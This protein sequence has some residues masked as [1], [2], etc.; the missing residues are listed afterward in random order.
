MARDGRL[1]PSQNA[2]RAAPERVPGAQ[3]AAMGVV[4]VQSR[5]RW[6]RRLMVGVAM[7]AMAASAPASAQ[8][9]NPVFRQPV[10][11]ARPHIDVVF[12]LDATGSMGDEIEPV[13]QHIW[14]IANQIAPG[15][16]ITRLV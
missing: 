1:H 8:R 4:M 7:A 9:Y 13:K 12:V 2:E 14:N 5:L 15:N 16:P 10:Q 11:V 3:L 6:V